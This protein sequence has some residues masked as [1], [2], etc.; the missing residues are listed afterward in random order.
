VIADDDQALVFVFVCHSLNEGITFL[1][2]IQPKVH[3]SM[4]YDFAAQVG[5]AQR[6]IHVQPGFVGQFGSRPEVRQ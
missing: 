6:S 5:Q 2:L 1:Q 3:M 4:R